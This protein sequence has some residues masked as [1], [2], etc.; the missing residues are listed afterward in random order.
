MVSINTLLVTNSPLPVW[1]TSLINRAF[2]ATREFKSEPNDQDGSVKKKK[3][4]FGVGGIHFNYMLFFFLVVPLLVFLFASLDR[5]VFHP[6]K[7]VKSNVKARSIIANTFAMMGV[8]ALSFF[9]VPVTRHRIFLVTFGWSP[10]HALRLHIIAGYVSFVCFAIHSALYIFDRFVLRDGRK[11]IFPHRECWQWTHAGKMSNSCKYKWFNFTGIVGLVFLAIL[12]LT[13]LNWFRRRYYRIFYICHVV[14]GTAILF[15]AILHWD[16]MV[17]Y[18][19]PS[20][21]YYAASTTPTLVQALAS[22]CRYGVQIVKVVPLRGGGVVEVRVAATRASAAVLQREPCMYVKV[23]VPSI[24]LVWHPFTVYQQQA[25][26]T[27]V[28]FMFRPVGSYTKQLANLLVQE[29]TTR[30]VVVMDG[31][32]R[33]GD[34]SNEALQHD[35]VIIAAGGVAISPFLS[36]IP[37]LLHKLK[38]GEDGT[39]SLVLHWVCREA[40]LIQFVQTQ[41]LEPMMKLAQASSIDFAIHVHHTGTTT[42]ENLDE[43]ETLVDA[44]K[45]VEPDDDVSAVETDENTPSCTTEELSVDWSDKQPEEE[46]NIEEW[47]DE[48]PVEA[49]SKGLPMEPARVM[50]GRE[51]SVWR[52]IPLFAV[53]SFGIWVGYCIIFDWF[54]YHP[55]KH[56]ELYGRGWGT[57]LYVVVIFAFA[58]LS[59]AAVLLARKYWPYTLLRDTLEV[60][61][62]E[63]SDMN[64]ATMGGDNMEHHVGRPSAAVILE[65]AETAECPGLFLCGPV[66]MTESIKAQAAKENKVFLTRFCVYEEPFEL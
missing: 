14:F 34:R 53:V 16:R 12:I 8:S 25:D 3:N 30:P 42:K 56:N 51:S 54:Q 23:C 58:L 36:M 50:P 29:T 55:N 66:S 2:A 61:D 44:E 15:A 4:Q 64:V 43:L 33:G 65:S 32:Y 27:T 11:N 17:V 13:S 6:D 38:S 18:L 57:L 47:S 46:L 49:N 62:I 7:P 60:E 63:D 20:I 19:L 31:F 28:R 45:G 41:Y 24:S 48:L 39:K 1:R 37:S 52:N 35:H 10:V 5:R 9:L 59:E 21:V 22:R 26:P 40:G